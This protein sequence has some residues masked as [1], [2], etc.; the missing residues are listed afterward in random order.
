LGEGEGQSATVNTAVAIPPSV[1][2]SDGFGNGVPGVSVTFAA[3]VGGGGVTGSPATTDANG[4]ARI[5]S[6]VLGPTPG[7]NELTATVAGVGSV[8]V[9][10][11]GVA[12]VPA[13]IQ[14][15]A[16]DGQ[17]AE[18]GTQ[19]GVAPQVR[20]TDAGGNPVPA[21]EV[22]FSIASGGGSVTG[23]TAF[24]D[25]DGRATVGSWTLGLTAGL[26]GLEASTPGLAHV[27]FSASGTPGTPVSMTVNGGDGQTAQAGS[28]VPLAPSVLIQDAHGNGVPGVSVSFAATAGGGSVTGSPAFSDGSGIATV[29]SWTLGASAGAN[30]LSAT[31]TGLFPVV[32][33]ATGIV[34]GG[35]DMELQFMTAVDPSQQAIF[36][37]AAARWEEIIVGDIPDYAGTLPA[38]GCQPVEESGG[39]DDVKVYVTVTAI[40]GSGGV[41]GRAGPCYI[42]N[43]GNAFPITGIVELDEADVANMQANGTLEDVIVH[44]LGHIL[45]IGTLWN[46][47]SND[48]LVGS[49]TS[50]PFFNGPAAIAAF[51][52]AGGDVRTDP[53]VPVENTGGAGTRN[54]HWRESVHNAE[55]MTGWIEGGG[56]PNPLSAITVGSLAD[57]GYTVNMDAADPYTLFNPMGAPPQGPRPDLIFIKELPPPTPIPIDPGGGGI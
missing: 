1:L 35:F 21:I 13:A 33:S 51:D 36:A 56:N 49:G 57:L 30:E 23:A 5:G 45:G 20:V 8:T 44:E 29:G 11:T 37:S 25:A 40:D 2:V 3:T 12:A 9:Q 48:F 42:W 15:T 22:T 6:W 55:L 53:K 26:N 17:T 24:T 54:S 32:F 46:A 39:V 7:P 31:A 4:E 28:V 10:A 14:K 16:G 38:G 43:P 27:T 34:P 19:V 41:L 50:D 52:A 47:Y 18:V